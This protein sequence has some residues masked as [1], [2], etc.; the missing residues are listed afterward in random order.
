MSIRL[1]RRQLAGGAAALAAAAVT[2]GL[3]RSG[4]AQAKIK[5]KYA[6]AGGENSTAVVFAKK[7]FAEVTKRTN[8]EIEFEVFAGTLG[9]EK[10]LI[11]G[12]ALGTVDMTT[13]A[14]T[15]TREFDILYAPYM[16][17]DAEHAG[18]VV[19]GVLRDR[20]AK[21]LKDRYNA[22]F[23]GV[24]RDGPFCLFTKAEIKSLGDIKGMKIRAGEIE[25][26]I[27]GLT[28]LGAAPTVVA[29]NEVYTALQQNLVD[30][31]VTLPNLALVMKFNEVCKYYVSN[32]F[33][34]GLGKWT[35]ASRV[36]DGLSEDHRKA[37]QDSFNEL[38]ANDYYAA[39][40]R[41]KP[42]DIKKWEELNGAG[43]V[44][45]FDAKAAQ[46]QMAPLNERL[47]TEVFGA[48][49]WDQI[50]KA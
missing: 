42:I 14:Y 46:D 26:V 49:A 38:E 11:D 12:L 28:H 10:T 31:M 33:G 7:V 36:W 1:T 24:A 15:G 37:I 43:T 47:A 29:F 17:R 22:E 30:G 13:T 45:N 27:A 18:K 39:V 34:I 48:G 6:N 21:V 20:F 25:G 40:Q 41:Q 8:G 23:L 3:P 9:G 19:N 5:I 32:D 16:F 2:T 35:I 4:R 50:Q 44:L